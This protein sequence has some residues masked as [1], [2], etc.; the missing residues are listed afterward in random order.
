[1]SQLNRKSYLYVGT[2]KGLDAW[3]L[4]EGVNPSEHGRSVKLASNG[5]NLLKLADAPI[6][7][8]EDEDWYEKTIW[9]EMAIKV[10]KDLNALER[11]SRRR[12]VAT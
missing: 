9:D 11:H 4:R 10:A 1:M 3:M 7:I 8:V 12:R 6:D 5:P 2:R